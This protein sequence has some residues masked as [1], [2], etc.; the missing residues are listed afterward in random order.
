MLANIAPTL[1]STGTLPLSEQQIRENALRN[2]EILVETRSH[3]AWGAAVTVQMLLPIERAVAWQQ[4]TTYSRWVEY[5]P[6]LSHSQVTAV[7]E[8]P[9]S[10]ERSIKHLHQIASKNFIFFTA[11]VEI[12][13]KVCETPQQRIQFELESGSFIDF[14]ADLS[15]QDFDSNCLLTYDVKATPALPIPSL[16]I[17]QAIHLDLPQN[18]RCMQKALCQGR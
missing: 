10:P 2:G 4:L 11:Q 15:L 7:R 13:L 18:L 8:H 14:S 16:F 12:N 6:A 5:F 9:H 3:T 1:Y 17:Q